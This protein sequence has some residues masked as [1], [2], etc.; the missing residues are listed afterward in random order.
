MFLYRNNIGEPCNKSTI[1][2]KMV[3][4]YVDLSR[5]ALR[6]SI[7]YQSDASWTGLKSAQSR[8][9][10]WVHVNPWRYR[11]ALS[12]RICHV[13]FRSGWEWNYDHRKLRPVASQGKFERWGWKADD[14]MRYEVREMVDPLRQSV[15]KLDAAAGTCACHSFRDSI[16][17]P[18]DKYSRF[19]RD[20]TRRIGC[21]HIHDRER[22]RQKL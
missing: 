19:H 14:K 3:K 10:R 11:C 17:H 9:S 16:R 12:F 6:I 2:L 21:T 13:P 5:E 15:I 18:R 22:H 1:K 7:C 8:E 20:I 4:W